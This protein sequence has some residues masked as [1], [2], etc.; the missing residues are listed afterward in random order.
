MFWLTSV[1]SASRSGASA[2]TSTVS[3]AEPTFSAKLCDVGT[4]DDY[5]AIVGTADL[6]TAGTV[7]YPAG[8]L[9]YWGQTSVDGRYCFVSLSQRNEVSVVDYATAREVARVPVGAFPQRE[10]IAKVDSSVLGSLH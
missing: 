5:T 8:S 4:I 2:F 7:T 9:P 1:F 10:R 3:V 6:S